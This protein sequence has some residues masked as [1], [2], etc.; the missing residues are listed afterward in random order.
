M[1]LVDL[2]VWM[3]TRKHVLFCIRDLL[4]VDEEDT[5]STTYIVFLST[6]GR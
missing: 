5:L 6:S 3:A 2:D 4:A 1:T